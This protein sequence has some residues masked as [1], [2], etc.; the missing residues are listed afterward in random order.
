VF[1]NRANVQDP[2][3]DQSNRDAVNVAAKLRGHRTT[4][5][6]Q[7]GFFTFELAAKKGRLA[8]CAG[9]RTRKGC[10]RKKG[11]WSG[12]TKTETGVNFQL[13]VTR[14]TKLCRPAAV[15]A[16]TPEKLQIAVVIRHR[17]RFELLQKS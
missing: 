4:T 7:L 11:A 17:F 3:T 2:W 15:V 5:A 14:M 6:R 10:R 1:V 12:V 8:K 16:H 13:V 9:I